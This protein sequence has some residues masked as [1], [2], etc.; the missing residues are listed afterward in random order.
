MGTLRLLHDELLRD[1][2]LCLVRG[3]AQLTTRNVETGADEPEGN[4]AESFPD[5]LGAGIYRKEA[6]DRVGLFDPSLWFAE[7]TDWHKRF[8]ESDLRSLRV[9]A[10]TL[11]VRRHGGN[12]TAQKTSKDLHRSL[13]ATFKR[14]L[15]RARERTG[16]A[17][18]ESVSEAVRT[19]V[20]I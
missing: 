16:A 5:Y 6:F 1:P 15:D 11:I 20:G 17:P 14:S 12:M 8:T 18:F 10:V 9:P 3:H 19:D 7:D 2:E 4:P 13:L